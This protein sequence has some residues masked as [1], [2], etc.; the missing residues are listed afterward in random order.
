MYSEKFL[1]LLAVDKLPVIVVFNSVKEDAGP[2]GFMVSSVPR[3]R[4]DDNITLLSPV[5]C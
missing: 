2:N 1:W 3:I 4:I 5:F